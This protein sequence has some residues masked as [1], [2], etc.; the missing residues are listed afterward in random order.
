MCFSNNFSLFQSGEPVKGA[1]KEKAEEKKKVS[2]FRKREQ[3][4]SQFSLKSENSSI[5]EEK[6]S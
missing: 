6:I 3:E 1:K 2:E 4:E 5:R